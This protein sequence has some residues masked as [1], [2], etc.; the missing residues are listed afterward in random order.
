MGGKGYER[1]GEFLTGGARGRGNFLR[2]EHRPPL[3][4]AGTSFGGSRG[5]LRVARTP[6]GEEPLPPLGGGQ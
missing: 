4:G 5:P 1:S 6:F 2:G 3:G